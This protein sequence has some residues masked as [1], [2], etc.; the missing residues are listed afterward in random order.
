MYWILCRNEELNCH[1][2]GR[3]KPWGPL[4]CFLK[5]VAIGCLCLNHFPFFHV[6]AEDSDSWGKNPMGLAQIIVTPPCGGVNVL[7]AAPLELIWSR[8]GGYFLKTKQIPP[9]NAVNIRRQKRIQGRL[10]EQTGGPLHL[11]VT[12]SAYSHLLV[13]RVSLFSLSKMI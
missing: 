6:Y 11:Q 3:E 1:L 4:I 2:L 9:Y 13:H 7:R 5:S 12:C 10:K 8:K